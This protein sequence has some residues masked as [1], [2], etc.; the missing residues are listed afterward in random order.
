MRAHFGWGHF[1]LQYAARRVPA[2]R[3]LV[4]VL[5]RPMERYTDKRA[6]EFDRING[7]ETARRC[8][9]SVRE[10]GALDELRWGYAAIN[11][12][13]F[14][15]I[16]ASIKEPLGSYTFVDVGS[17]KGAAVILASGHAFRHVV[18]VELSAELIA[19]AHA[20]VEKY[21]AVN[22]RHLKPEWIRTDF[23]KWELP[24]EKQFFFLNNPFPES[25]T[26]QAIRRIEASVS[27]CPRPM[28]MAFRKASNGVAQYLNASKVWQPIRL[29]P[30]WRIYRAVTR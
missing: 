15:E 16:V 17:G 22:A 9:V 28:L 24:P 4:R 21:N 12:D 13:F 18:G 6:E 3:P 29:A 25:I 19:I 1:L 30:Y 14:H 8:Y 26:I 27:S 5:H 20:N 2:T 10:G 23:L 11:P 7:T